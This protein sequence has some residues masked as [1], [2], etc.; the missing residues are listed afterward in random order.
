M[1][2]RDA[3]RHTCCQQSSTAVGPFLR[4][5]DERGLD[6]DMVPSGTDFAT[7]IRGAVSLHVDCWQ[8]SDWR[9]S[10]VARHRG[11]ARRAVLV[12]L[13]KDLERGGMAAL[14]STRSGPEC[15]NQA[16]LVSQGG[17]GA[18]SLRSRSARLGARC[19]SWNGELSQ[20]ETR[21][22][23]GSVRC[24]GE[25][26]P[27]KQGGLQLIAEPLRVNNR[28][29]ILPHVVGHARWCEISRHTTERGIRS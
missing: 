7:I 12:T 21:F 23:V 26:Q 2:P 28:F 25:K 27:K 9:W 1:R 3:E 10:T 15:I 5:T 8:A 24:M 16:R 13:N 20:T 4:Q 19:Q 18:R 17:V 14:V 6:E 11:K 22:G 29:H